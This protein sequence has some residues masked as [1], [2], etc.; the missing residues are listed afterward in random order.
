MSLAILDHVA[1]WSKTVTTY[2]ILPQRCEDVIDSNPASNHQVA[3]V[4]FSLRGHLTENLTCSK[5]VKN[6]GI[7]PLWIAVLIYPSFVMYESSLLA[8]F[9]IYIDFGIKQPLCLPQR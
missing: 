3:F 4:G 2:L 6:P 8:S 9:T 5:H 7:Q 1:K